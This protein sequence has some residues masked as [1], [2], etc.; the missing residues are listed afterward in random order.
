MK[1]HW[2]FVHKVESGLNCNLCGKSCQNMLKLKKHT[3]MC[4]SRDPEVVA[5]ERAKFEATLGSKENEAS[6]VEKENHGNE[7]VSSLLEP[8]E[9]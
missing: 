4:L 5:K 8:F 7:F 2:N 6:E 1:D 9:F 3:Q